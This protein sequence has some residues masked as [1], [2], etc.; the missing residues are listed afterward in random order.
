MPKPARKRGEIRIPGLEG[1]WKWLA[2]KDGVLYVLAGKPGSGAETVKGDR[3]FGGWSWEDL[4]K[5]YYPKR[6]PHGFGDLLAAWHIADKKLLWKHKETTLI[7]SRGMAMTGDKLFLYCPDRH[8]RCLTAATGNIQWTNNDEKVLELIEQPGRGLTSTPGWR[9]QTLTVATPDVLI[10]QGQTRMNVVALSADQGYL[11]WTKKK[12][13]NNPNVIHVDGKVVLGVGPDGSIFKHIL[14]Y[15]T[16]KAS[17]HVERGEHLTTVRISSRAKD[18]IRP[19]RECL[20]AAR[21][22]GLHQFFGH[23]GVEYV[24]ILLVDELAIHRVMRCEHVLQT[25]TPALTVQSEKRRRVPRAS[26]GSSG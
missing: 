14:D 8:F 16:A 22:Y 24:S 11:R 20:Q 17:G 15:S 12:I 21:G 26:F 13:T 9:T 23:G 18:P 10:V 1:E 5:G 19:K 4:S 25:R 7:D 3:T 6:I 2:M